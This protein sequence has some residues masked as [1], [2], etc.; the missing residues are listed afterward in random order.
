M[1]RTFGCV[2][3]QLWSDLRPGA[4]PRATDPASFV[5]SRCQAG[6]V[7]SEARSALLW[8]GDSTGLKVM[9][10]PIVRRLELPYEN[11]ALPADPELSMMTYNPEPGT[12]AGDAIKLL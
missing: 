12:P 6:T 11:F 4:I 7:R 8:G 2:R 5:R 10:H 1:P 9:R 3:R